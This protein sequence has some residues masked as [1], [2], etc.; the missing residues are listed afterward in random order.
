MVTN[1][2]ENNGVLVKK[3]RMFTE[4]IVVGK[5]DYSTQVYTYII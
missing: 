3:P 5:G 4:V 2:K 1:E